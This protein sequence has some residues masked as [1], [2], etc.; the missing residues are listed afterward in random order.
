MHMPGQPADVPLPHAGGP[1]LRTRRRALAQI[2]LCQGCCCGRSDRGMPVVPLD[3]LKPLWK[4]ERLNATVQLTVSGCLGPCDLPNVTCV[5]TPTEQ[6]WFGRLSTREDYAVLVDW[7]RR[8]KA[9]AT[10]LPLP[11]DLDHLR[12]DR[13]AVGEPPA[14][15]I[16]QDPADLLLLT[17]VDTDLAAWSAALGR[18]PDGFPTVRALNLDRLRDRA[19][20]DAY[21][22][23]V[24]QDARAVLVRPLGGLGYWREP[25]DELLVLA[26]T[27]AIALAVVPG[28]DRP[29]AALLPYNT[30]PP[31]VADA[32]WR[33]CA[34][35]GVANAASLLCSLADAM[36]GTAFRAEPPRPL[37]VTG[38]YHP[39]AGPDGLLDA[40][41]W[42]ARFG[43]SSRPVAGVAFYRAHWAAGNLAAVDALVR[44]LE[45]HGFAVRAAFGPDLGTLADTGLLPPAGLDVLITTTNFRTAAGPN[46]S[47]FDCPVLQAV[48]ASSGE[49]AW[50]ANPAGL[51][52]R[53][54][55]M[56]VALPEL[57]G[58]LITTAVAFKSSAEHDSQLQSPVP[59]HRARPDRVEFVAELARR[60][61]RLRHTPNEAKCIA[62]IVGNYPSKNARLGNAVGLDTPAS[63]HALL[64]AMRDAGY[65]LGPD[66]LPPDGQT[67]FEQLVAA[68]VQ[69]AEFATAEAFLHAPGWADGADVRRWLD[70]LPEATRLAVERQWGGPEASPL[71]VPERGGFPVPG[72]RFGN[73]FVGVQPSRGYDQDPSAVYH[74][75]DLPPPPF[76]VAFYAWLRERF[77]ADAVVHL[78]KHGNLE[79]LPGKGCALSDACF[80]EAVLGPLPVVYPFIVN[81]PGEGTQA[82]RRSA[83]VVVDHLVP[84]MTDAGVYADLRELEGLMDE[85]ARAADLDPAKRPR[86]L[87]RIAEV[88]ANAELHRDLDR[89]TPPTPDEMPAL[90][91]R[92]DGYLCDIK[93]A[94]IRD[95]LHI[96]GRTP[97]GEQLVG[98]ALALVR[99]R[100]GGVLGLAEAVAADGGLPVFPPPPQGGRE[101]DKEAGYLRHLVEEALANRAPADAGPATRRTLAFLADT[102]LQR[103]RRTPDEI[104]HVIRALDGRFVPPGPSGAPTRG[105]CDVLPTG[106]NFFSLDVRGVPTPTAWEVGRAA[107]AALL[108]R[109]RERTGGYPESV[110]MVAW[111]TSNMRT[112]GDDIAEVLALL[113]VRPRWDGPGGRVVGLDAVPLAELGRPRIDVTLRISGLFRDAFP[114]L[115]RLVNDAVA[116]VC[117]LDEPLDRN[118]VKANA[119]RDA[120]RLTHATGGEMPEAE[121]ERLARLR[122]FGSK[123]GA[124]G[125]GLLP[126]IDGRNWQTTDDITEVYLTWGSY[127]YTGTDAAD[128]HGEPAID[129]R[130]ERTAFR[131]RLASTD[132]VLQNQ[133]NRE[134]DIFDSDDYFQFHGGLVTAVTKLSG[135]PPEAYLGDTSRP[136]SPAARTLREE[137]LRVFR[138]RVVNPRW[139]AGVMRHGYKGAGEM[140]ATVDYLFGYDATT[141]VVEDW[142]YERLAAAYLFDAA[143][144]DWLRRVNPWAERAMTERLLEAADRG[145]WGAA[146][147]TLDRLRGLYEAN[148]AGLESR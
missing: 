133:D 85:Y 72:L 144:S 108:E 75:P 43:G 81:D 78:G 97:D 101:Q 34:A 9:A 30:V 91:P 124:Y 136:E 99:Q 27:H 120:A 84:P 70:A 141:N 22:D 95:G 102:V 11:A 113:G 66:P 5:V 19:V 29:D 88:V 36:L 92:L 42:D 90:L 7:A 62:V 76:Y 61:A 139:L 6:T 125:A 18:L 137:A 131:L 89:D 13:W 64:T 69:D 24:V 28:D 8:C 55:A 14:R 130:E 73:V 107:A 121:A 33:Y 50:A 3:W 46:A 82:K 63:L 105:R 10:L 23:E 71:W 40:A 100:Q 17:A 79:W 53:D 48:L 104:A 123:P 145:L 126:L 140:A 94:Q 1:G 119:V 110:A 103:L 106:R 135:K 129:G 16:A 138:S 51:P 86:L 58:R 49:N 87:V 65:D 26:R 67:L 39:D 74:S 96:L 44:A 122:V 57:D 31:A 118:F 41:C 142:M 56:S 147:E 32:A 98:L 148:E 93:A 132:V 4:S 45:L 77:A 83:A 116:L 134:H 127:A 20:R 114:H 111:G 109:H 68:S 47:T 12:F 38:L 37:P 59:R 52:P 112:G 54:L 15:R 60:H 21:L 115:V 25:L 35:G 128:A 80:P 2:V 117:G 146:P 143:V